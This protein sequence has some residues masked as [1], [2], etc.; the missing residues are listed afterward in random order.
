LHGVLELLEDACGHAEPVCLS[1]NPVVGD[2]SGRQDLNLRP[3]AP[4]PCRPLST[5]IG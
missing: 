5:Q 1:N 3:S 2:W 4:K